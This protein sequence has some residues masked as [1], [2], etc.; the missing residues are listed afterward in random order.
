MITSSG[1]NT[2]ADPAMPFWTP[3]TI[4]A[5]TASHTSTQVISTAGT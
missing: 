4:T 3:K 2:I 5:I 1:M